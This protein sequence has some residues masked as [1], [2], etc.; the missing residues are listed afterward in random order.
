MPGL[1]PIFFL[2]LLKL[3]SVSVCTVTILIEG[4]FSVKTNALKHTVPNGEFLAHAPYRHHLLVDNYKSK[5]LTSSRIS[6]NR[7]ENRLEHLNKLIL[8]L[9]FI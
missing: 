1:Y 3:L 5:H 8:L 7:A 6:R 9:F 2:Q 4:L